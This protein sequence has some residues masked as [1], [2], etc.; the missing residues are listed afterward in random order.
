M[1]KRTADRKNLEKV[2]L[3]SRITH[4]PSVK[5]IIIGLI[6]AS[7]VIIG[8]LFISRNADQSSV[9]SGLPTPIGFPRT[10]Q[11]V[12]T[13]V[14]QVAPAFTLIDDRGQSVT[15]SPGQTERPIVLVFNMGFG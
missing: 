15:V 4:R 2:S 10:A 1:K 12:G 9:T 13:M 6:L 7:T 8:I 5:R 11:D 14:G 3:W